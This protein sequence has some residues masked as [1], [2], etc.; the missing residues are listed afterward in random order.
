[1]KM[2]C[3]AKSREDWGFDISVD[4]S[5]VCNL[6]E[7]SDCTESR[8]TEICMACNRIIFDEK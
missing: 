4:W 6:R 3:L 1:M 7:S 5:K 8:S 2:S